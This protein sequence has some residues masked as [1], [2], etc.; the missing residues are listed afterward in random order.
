MT[1]E[2]TYPQSAT[3]R[4]L[5][6]EFPEETA[7]FKRTFLWSGCKDGF[8]VRSAY[9]PQTFGDVVLQKW[10]PFKARGRWQPLYPGLVDSLA[11]KH[12][13]FDRFARF[14]P[15]KDRLHPR[16]D[17]SAFWVGTMAGPTTL[18]HTIDIDNHAY[19]GW[20][21]VPTRW[22]PSRT[23]FAPGPWSLR[24]LPVIRPNLSFFQMAKRVHDHFPNR[25]WSFSSANLG[26]GIWRLFR[27]PQQTQALYQQQA[28]RLSIAGVPLLEHYPKPATGASLGKC[29][30]RPCGLDSSVI[31][32]TGI[33]TDPIEQI[34]WFMSPGPTPTFS[35]I[36]AAYWQALDHMYTAFMACGESLAHTGL[37][38]TL[39]AA[40]VDECR[41]VIAQVKCWEANGCPLD[42][43]LP[44]QILSNTD[45]ETTC[46][47][48]P[49][50]LLTNVCS[51][52]E[53]VVL[54]QAEVP[55]CFEQVDLP[56][57]V[58]NGQWLQFI[59]YVVKNGIPAKDKFFEVISTLAKW[60]VFVEMYGDALS[61]IGAV[62]KQ[63]VLSKHNNRVTRLNNGQITE[64]FGHVDRILTSVV[65]D[66][67]PTGLALFEDIRRRRTT[68]HY[69]EMWSF[70]PQIMRE[71]TTT[72]SSSL[73]N[74]LL[75][76]HLICGSLTQPPDA[77]TVPTKWTYEPDNT[78]LPD[79]VVERIRSAFQ[80]RNRQLRKGKD[81]SFP[82]LN[83]IT[84]FFNY[85]FSGQKSG[86]RRASREL[87]IKMGFPTN[88]QRRSPIINLL[89]SS[90]LV[91]KGGYLSM[92]KSRLWTLAS[93]IVEAIRLHR[94]PQSKPDC[95]GSQVQD[96]LR[97][98]CIRPLG[99]R[100]VGRRG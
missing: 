92:E 3:N 1:L 99:P 43:G 37:S 64:V 23:G 62:L 4:R 91:T 70:A 39:K 29:H 49:T 47:V 59:H 68:G 28:R 66:E 56:T 31:T 6:D 2:H 32:P 51:L 17:E 69:A 95:C 85:L 42:E 73:S 19:I 80:A 45:A 33:I 81:G 87:L 86:T 54:S 93:D 74:M 55:D 22:H 98:E 76:S 27:S 18:T 75:P 67:S 78:P 44:E 94:S 77:V 65:K 16:D 14:H 84:R 97:N 63:Y 10:R 41:K 71:T 96:A 83:A 82:T 53:P 89:V 100:W 26:L 35:Q 60:F 13:D 36:L 40:L 11:E 57:I 7:F 21:P 25:I 48:P 79:F 72:S 34:R 46:Y 24:D 15:E 61:D 5:I 30:R 12:L 58:N 88:G 20:T 90:G 8:Y 52:R 38:V 50:S 9:E